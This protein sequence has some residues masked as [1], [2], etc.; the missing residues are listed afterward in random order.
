MRKP[1]FWI[2]SLLAILLSALF[3]FAVSSNSDRAEGIALLSPSACPSGGCAAGQ[4][5]NFSLSYSVSPQS[6]GTNTQV[7]V[8]AP[9]G[10]WADFSTGWISDKGLVSSET[11]ELG[12]TNALCSTNLPTGYTWLAGASGKLPVETSSDQLEIA[13]NIRATATSSGSLL[14]R[15]YEVDADGTEWSQTG[16]FTSASLSVAPLAQTVFVANNST[17]CGANSPCF[18]N[19]GDDL[20]KGLGTGLRDAINAVSAGDTIQVLGD[21][22]VKDKTV[23]LDKDVTLT[24]VGD[25]SLTYYGSDCSNPLLSVTS[26]AVIQ[27][28]TLDGG[29]CTSSSRTLIDIDSAD[30]VAIHHNTLMDGNVGVLVQN[31]TGQVDIAF[32]AFEK[33]DSYAV[34]QEYSG[35]NVL[36]YANNIVENANGIQVLCNAEGQADHNFWGPGQTA[37]SSVLGCQVSKCKELGAAALTISGTPGVSAELVTVTNSKQYA[38]NDQI[39]YSRSDSANYDLVIVNHGQ[40]SSENVPFYDVLGNS[41]S[42]CSNYY[43]IFLAEG[44]SPSS[45]NLAFRYDLN[46]DCTAKI[47]SPTSPYCASGSMAKYPLWWYDPAAN[48]TEYWDT[49]GQ[50]PEGKGAGGAPGQITSCDTGLNE[51]Q[52]TLNNLAANRPRLSTDLGFTPFVVGLP[53][54]GGVDLSQFT[55]T[56]DT[57]QNKIR[58][59]TTAE[60]NVAG[61]HV[62]RSD[63]ENGTYARISPLIDSIGDT[64]I[65]ASYYFNDESIQYTRTYYYKLEVVNMQGVSV[66]FHGPVSVITSTATP[67]STLTQTPTVTRTPY[68]TRTSTPYYYRSPTSYYLRAT[69]TPIGSGPTQVR[70]YGPSPTPSRTSATK[71]TYDPT[72]DGY[73]SGEYPVGTESP[74]GSDGY[75]AE[76]GTGAQISTPTPDP[77]DGPGGQDSG[78]PGQEQGKNG[79]NPSQGGQSDFNGQAIQWPYM[80]LGAGMG[81]LALG[82]LSWLLI[83]TRVH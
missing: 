25:A 38:F 52:V 17:A 21:Y 45:L 67:T 55:V 39:A 19:S 76:N 77:N 1:P 26:G 58:W 16:E 48:V 78:S 40:G 11:Y 72:S 14:F 37:A 80:T 18:I 20:A 59:T 28:L 10:G 53:N 36:I 41:I 61:F 65:W 73:P 46:V 51:I 69:A 2:G 79:G 3:V 9:T 66:E 42:P 83:K 6:T 35:S 63:S 4:R 31:N 82:L 60:S 34:Y 5:L 15:V 13:L 44:E 75:P 74:S 43:D 32:N 7:C 68:P 29:A 24:G 56:F 64:D 23:L 81:L 27:N 30:E 54:D 49:T 70:T 33:Q 12:E 71:P 22:L 47:E 62:L 8:Y 57:T 50:A